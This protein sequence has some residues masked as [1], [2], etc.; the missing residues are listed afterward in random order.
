M[1]CTVCVHTGARVFVCVWCMQLL[2]VC[3][4]VCVCVCV[5]VFVC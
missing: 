1:W 4:H 2:C 5:C 3:V